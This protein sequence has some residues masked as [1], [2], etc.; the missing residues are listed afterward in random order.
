LRILYLRPVLR[1][2]S[3]KEY[4]V[5]GLLPLPTRMIN[6]IADF[7]CLIHIEHEVKM[8]LT[9]M[10]TIILIKLLACILGGPVPEP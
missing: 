7:L 6:T 5:R 2:L 1:I 9:L 3:R 10:P 4:R 8:A